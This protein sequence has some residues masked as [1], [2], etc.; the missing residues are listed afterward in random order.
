LRRVESDI[1][2][3]IF[4]DYAGGVVEGLFIDID[5]DILDTGVR[6][7]IIAPLDSLIQLD[8]LPHEVVPTEEKVE[9]VEEPVVVE[10]KSRPRV[11]RHSTQDT[12]E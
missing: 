5:A 3:V 4:D 12:S 11:R 10:S 7:V 6:R 8:L 9:V 1:H 2:V